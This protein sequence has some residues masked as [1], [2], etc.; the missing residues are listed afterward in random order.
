MRLIDEQYMRHPEFGY[1]RMTDYICSQGYAVNNKRIYR[2][3]KLMGLQAITPGPHTSKPSKCHKTYPYLLNNVKVIRPNQVWSTDFTYV[4]MRNGFMYLT[5]IIDWYSR[6]ILSW[7]LS[8]TMENSFCISCLEE[9]LYK[10]YFPEIFNTDQGSQ[11]TSENFTKVLLDRDISISMD[12]KGR[13]I[14]NVY[15]ERFWWTVKYEN[16][17]P[18]AYEDVS[19]LYSGLQK[20]IC[21]Y[22]NEREHSSIGKNTPQQVYSGLAI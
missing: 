2:L 21:Y 14:D 17:F 16:I 20:Y 22:N 15:I 19:E 5:A 12:G 4:P 11:Y 18:R 9:A 7:E 1:P 3:M 6:Y 8:N 13:A 10:Y